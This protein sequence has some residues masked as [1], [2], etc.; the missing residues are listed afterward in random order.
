M[1]SFERLIP[2]CSLS[3][4]QDAVRFIR[5]R[6]KKYELMITPGGLAAFM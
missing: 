6:T 3:H 5:L 4:P 2:L 1:G